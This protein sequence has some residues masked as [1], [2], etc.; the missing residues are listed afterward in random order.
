LANKKSSEDGDVN[1]KDVDDFKILKRNIAN[2]KKQAER[3]GLQIDDL[4]K[5]LKIELKK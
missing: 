4:I 2:L 1:E 5:F 3:Q